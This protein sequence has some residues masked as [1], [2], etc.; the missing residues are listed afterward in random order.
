MIWQIHITTFNN[1]AVG[2]GEARTASVAIDAV[3]FVIGS[4]VPRLLFVQKKIFVKQSLRVGIPKLELGNE[5]K[6]LFYYIVIIAVF[7]LAIYSI[8]AVYW[9]LS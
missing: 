9:L 1:S 2:C 4:F 6:M 7:Q 3:Q 8:V 5:I